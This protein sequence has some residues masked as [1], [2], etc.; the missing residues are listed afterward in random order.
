MVPSR[1]DALKTL[2]PLALA[3]SG[4]SGLGPLGGRE[5]GLPIPTR[6]RYEFRNP[7]GVARPPD[8]PLLISSRSPFDDDPLLAAVDPSDGTERWEVAG[9]EGRGS[10]VA[11]DEEFAYVFSRSETA[12]AVDYRTGQIAWEQSVT[13]LDDADPG[14]VA[15]PPIPLG[16][17]VVLPVSG[18]EDDVPDRLVGLATADGEPRFEYDLPESLAGMPGAGAGI[19][20]PL[21]DGTLR[22][23]RPDGTEAWTLSLDAPPAAVTVA[24]G[25]AYA[26]TAGEEL[27][28]VDTGSG[29]VRWRAPLQNTVFTSPLVAD[30]RVFVGAADYYLYAFDTGSGERQWRT[31]TSN[32]VT[33]G[34]AM[35]DGRLVTM[36]GGTMKNRGPSGS[37]PRTPN[38][39][40]VHEPDGT[41]IDRYGF[42]LGI[43]GGRP[44]WIAT[45]DGG[46]YLGQERTVT[47]LD[48]VILG[49][50]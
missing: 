4:C 39:L 45:V 25:T 37:V 11:A 10:P 15:Y 18:A 42:D 13:P 17:V 12:R 44:R 32:A 28:A 49:D 31:E 40:Y 46:V 35:A 38:D 7:T 48:G 29:E 23:I 26:G 36:V 19:V 27:L 3:L 6:W 41:R 24:D 14:V 50:G 20:A 34:P 1:R 22:R 8:G 43:D 5:E 9:V 30:G 21:L 33:G 16:D 2:P 47:R